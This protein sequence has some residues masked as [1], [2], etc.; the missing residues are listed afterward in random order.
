MDKTPNEMKELAVATVTSALNARSLESQE[1]RIKQFAS[2]Y[3]M[4][5]ED[6]DGADMFRLSSLLADLSASMIEMMAH[7]MDSKP[8]TVM[9]YLAQQMAETPIAENEE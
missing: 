8:E 6:A 2:D 5:M 9:A 7:M 1:D 4:L 3:H